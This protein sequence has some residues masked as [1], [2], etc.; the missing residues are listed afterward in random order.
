MG[1]NYG[2]L[3]QAP[4]TIGAASNILTG[5]NP[6]YTRADFLAWYPQ[7]TG[8]ISDAMLDQFIAM[9]DATVQQARWNELWSHGMANYIAHFATLYIE[10]VG[11]GDGSTASQVIKSAQAAG[12]QTSKSV[13]DVSVSY[14]FSNSL[15]GIESWGQWTT[16]KFG[17]QFASMAKILTKAGSYVW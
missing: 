7:F 10:A 5:T 6:A 15:K 2:Y 12:L 1:L 13:G 14:D 4:V 17:Q 3:G 11:G 8:N 9:A 16:T